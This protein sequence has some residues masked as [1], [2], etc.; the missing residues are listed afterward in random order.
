MTYQD[1]VDKL[2]LVNKLYSVVHPSTYRSNASAISDTGA[3]GNYLK[4][5]APL[6]AHHGQ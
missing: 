3:S 2:K 6:T 1:G 4:V 5:D